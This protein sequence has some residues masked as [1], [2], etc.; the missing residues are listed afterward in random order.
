MLRHAR[1]R[2]GSILGLELR[3]DGLCTA[4]AGRASYTRRAEPLQSTR[5]HLTA[6][7]FSGE[8]GGRLAGGSRQSGRRREPP[9]GGS[10]ARGRDMRRRRDMHP[11][12]ISPPPNSAGRNVREVAGTPGGP[13]RRFWDAACAY[14]RPGLVG[15][16]RSAAADARAADYRP[17][18]S[19]Q[20]RIRP[21]GDRSAMSHT[22]RRSDPR[23]PGYAPILAARVI[24]GPSRRGRDAGGIERGGRAVRL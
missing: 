22:G 6:D 13:A 2:R 15:K 1:V 11:I 10:G 16:G 4:L 18:G 9:S 7:M 23:R 21:S 5:F 19:M 17:N 14:C 12:L 3:G 20:A 24:F 8:V